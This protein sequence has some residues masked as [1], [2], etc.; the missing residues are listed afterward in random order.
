MANRLVSHLE[1]TGFLHKF[2]SAY[3]RFN[4]TETTTVKVLS[5]WRR[6]LDRGERVIV[7][8]LDVTAAFDTVHHEILFAV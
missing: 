3:R 8:S 7:A 5:N 6:A 2:Q 4:S 1:T